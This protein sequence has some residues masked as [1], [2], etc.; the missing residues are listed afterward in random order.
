[1]TP[2]EE[3][4]EATA[5]YAPAFQPVKEEPFDDEGRIKEA[6]KSQ[7]I[8]LLSKLDRQRPNPSLGVG[9]SE[10]KVYNMVE[11]VDILDEAHHSWHEHF[12]GGVA[13]LRKQMEVTT[14]T[15]L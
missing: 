13:L 7:F 3:R 9:P 8:P 14:I 5:K 11:I 4:A 2:E 6:F 1:M 15:I 10:Q 12:E